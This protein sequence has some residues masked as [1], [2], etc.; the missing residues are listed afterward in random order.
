MRKAFCSLMVLLGLTSGAFG[1]MIESLGQGQATYSYYGVPFIYFENLSCP[2]V[3]RVTGSFTLAQPFPPNYSGDIRDLGLLSYDFTDG[4]NVF[5]N[6]N[7]NI[8]YAAEVRTDSAGNIATWNLQFW[9]QYDYGPPYAQI[10]TSFIDGVTE[11]V[12]GYVV[13]PTQ[14]ASYYGPESGYWTGNRTG[15]GT[16][17]SNSARD[18]SDQDW[19][20]LISDGIQFVVVDAWMGRN[21]NSYAQE[22]LLGA[23]RNGLATAAYVLL[24]YD[25]PSQ[26]GAYQVGQALAAIGEA[27]PEVKFLAID[28]ERIDVPGDYELL[29]PSQFSNRI[30][31]IRQAVN[32]AMRE[33]GKAIVIY[34]DRGAWAV[35]TNNCS[36]NPSNNCSDLVSL[37]LWDTEHFRSRCGDGIVGLVPFSPFPGYSG[38]RNRSGNQFDT[39][40]APGCNGTIL[41][42]VPVDLDAFDA[43]LFQ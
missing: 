29:P 4:V 38:W 21:R 35:I 22:Q 6:L 39:G 36:N 24:N 15:L 8:G 41:A 17:I 26:N 10:C 5:T 12:T 32:T 31:E 37:P 33:T 28:V 42:G 30:A 1:Q 18:V 14:A 43:S 20:N 3:C 16:D 7:S 19:Q 27:L 40:R 23:Q 13:D 9:M 25:T 11:D 34:T 2:P